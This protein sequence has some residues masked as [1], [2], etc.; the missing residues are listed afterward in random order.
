MLLQAAQWKNP[1]F[2]EGQVLGPLS[3]YKDLDVYHWPKL[4]TPGQQALLLTC[5][6][7]QQ[8]R[9]AWSSSGTDGGK[10]QLQTR[11]VRGGRCR[12]LYSREGHSGERSQQNLVLTVLS[13]C[14]NTALSVAC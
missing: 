2:G 3:G 8:R 14:R 11:L 6:L 9:E 10:Q 4:F 1:F 12:G 5:H 7:P 13:V